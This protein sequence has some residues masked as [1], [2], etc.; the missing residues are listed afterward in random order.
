MTQSF[1]EACALKLHD[2][3]KGKKKKKEII[4]G[5]RD[6]KE[7][8]WHIDMQFQSLRLQLTLVPIGIPFPSNLTTA[9]SF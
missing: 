7:L 5:G 8:T 2:K 4:L 3:P 6:S 1:W 9:V